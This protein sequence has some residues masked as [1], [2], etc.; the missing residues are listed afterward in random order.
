MNWGLLAPL[1]PMAGRGQKRML[2]GL[3]ELKLL[4]P[5]LSEN[6]NRQHINRQVIVVSTF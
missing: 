2:T 1:D 5:I 3:T 6:F 4:A